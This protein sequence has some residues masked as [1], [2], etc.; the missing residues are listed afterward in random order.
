MR[1]TWQQNTAHTRYVRGSSKSPNLMLELLDFLRDSGRILACERNFDRAMVLVDRLVSSYHVICSTLLFSLMNE[2]GLEGP[3]QLLSGE[4]L[5]FEEKVLTK[6]QVKDGL[7]LVSPQRKIVVDVLIQDFLS[8]SEGSIP[9]SQYTCASRPDTIILDPSCSGTGLLEH[10]D[11]DG[12][13]PQRIRNLAS[14][15]QRLLLHA[16]TQFPSVKRVCYSTCSILKEENEQVVENALAAVAKDQNEYSSV[17]AVPWLDQSSDFGL[18]IL[19]IENGC[20]GFFIAKLDKNRS[21]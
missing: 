14:F 5:C 19:P 20:R 10:G 21:E 6:E 3:Y 1:C 18:T 17:T 15:Q 11:D 13:S 4:P 8:L 12:P 7:R 2:G 16:L 9:S